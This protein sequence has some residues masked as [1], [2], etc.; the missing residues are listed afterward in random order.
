MLTLRGEAF[1][2]R[3]AASLYA[4]LAYPVEAQVSALGV[5]GRDGSD[6]TR[7][8]GVWSLKRQHE[9]QQQQEEG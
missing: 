3:V 2:A 5:H 8:A 1:P 7:K 6:S 4:S 9:Q